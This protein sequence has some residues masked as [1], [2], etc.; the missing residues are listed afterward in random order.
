ME[1][2]TQSDDGKTNH[3]RLFMLH[4][5]IF[6]IYDEILYSTYTGSFTNLGGHDGSIAINS[7]FIYESSI[8]KLARTLRVFGWE[9]QVSGN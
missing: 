5:H 7:G 1:R 4:V 8:L 6:M 3:H 9:F 2:P